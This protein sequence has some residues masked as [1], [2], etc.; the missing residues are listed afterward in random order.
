[1]VTS[2]NTLQVDEDDVTYI[3]GEWNGLSSDTKPMANVYNGSTFFE[4]DTKK[5]FMFDGENKIWR[6]I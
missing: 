1:M 5:G 4:M 2:V 3:Y 6:E